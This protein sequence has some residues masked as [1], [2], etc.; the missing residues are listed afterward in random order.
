MQTE[1][2]IWTKLKQNGYGLRWDKK[3]HR[4]NLAH[5]MAW[6]E[7]NGPV[8]KGMHL[9]HECRNKA[10]VNPDHLVIIAPGDHNKI[11]GPERFEKALDRFASTWATLRV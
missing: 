3:R 8:P 6:E 5:R 11:H 4:M 7:K 1:C 9:H 10:C 2:V